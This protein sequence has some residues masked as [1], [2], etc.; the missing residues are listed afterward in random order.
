MCIRDSRHTVSPIRNNSKLSKNEPHISIDE[1]Y[2]IDSDNLAVLYAG[3]ETVNWGGKTLYDGARLNN[4][5]LLYTSRRDDQP[6]QVLIGSFG[7]R[8]IVLQEPSGHK[9]LD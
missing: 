4:N 2:S 6:Q 3:Y 7:Q 8:Q 1:Y 5:C 9:P